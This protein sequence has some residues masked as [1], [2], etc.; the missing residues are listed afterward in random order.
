MHYTST[1]QKP[2]TL[3]LFIFLLSCKQNISA[4][5]ETQNPNA[6][7]GLFWRIGGNSAINSGSHFLGTI[8]NASLRIRTVNTERMVID[9]NGRVGI[10]TATPLRILHVAGLTQGIRYAGVATGGSY[11]TTPANTTDKILFADANG[12]IRAIPGGSTGELLTYTATGPDWGIPTTFW[13]TTAMPEPM[14]V[15]ILLALRIILT[16]A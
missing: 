8:N 9:S 12:D 2:V 16:L 5:A 7:A 13:R 14:R 3:L 15:Q 11:I 10:G 4:Q 1:I 6:A